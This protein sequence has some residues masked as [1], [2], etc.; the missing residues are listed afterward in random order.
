MTSSTTTEGCFYDVIK[1]NF[2]LVSM[3]P[4]LL[5]SSLSVQGTNRTYFFHRVTLTTSPTAKGILGSS[6][7]GGRHPILKPNEKIGQ[8]DPLYGVTIWY[9]RVRIRFSAFCS[10]CSTVRVYASQPSRTSQSIPSP[11]GSQDKVRTWRRFRRLL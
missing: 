11:M 7:Q 1:W 5:V 4:I 6:V 10:S 3:S 8:M 9:S 2:E